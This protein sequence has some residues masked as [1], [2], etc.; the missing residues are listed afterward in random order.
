MG[1]VAVQTVVALVVIDGVTELV[2]AKEAEFG[3]GVYNRGRRQNGA[4][5][6][7]WRSMTALLR[8]SSEVLGMAAVSARA[9]PPPP[10]PPPHAGRAMYAR[11]AVR[12][13]STRGREEVV[14]LVRKIYLSRARLQTT[15]DADTES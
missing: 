6:F 3:G 9:P 11:W 5:S 10:L 13:F 12:T 4:I 1:E 15:A 8:T 14:G 7:T 2:E